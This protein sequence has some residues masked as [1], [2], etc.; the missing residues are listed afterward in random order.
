M[1]DTLFKLNHPWSIYLREPISSYTKYSIYHSELLRLLD[2]IVNLNI[3]IKNIKDNRVQ[4]TNFII[5]TPME[6]ALHKQNCSNIYMFQWQQLFPYHITKF[7]NY[8]EKLN[9]YVNINIIIISPDD[10]FMDENYKEPLFTSQCMDYKFTKVKNREYN[11]SKEKLTIKIDIFTCPF[12]QLEK[13][14]LTILK[15]DELI[16]KIAL[17]Q[18]DTLAPSLDDIKFIDNFYEHIE[19]IA[20]NPSSNMIINS[21]ATFRNVREYDNYGL[22]K[23][24]LELANK[25]KIIATEWSFSENNYFTKIMSTIKFTTDYIKYAVSYIDPCYSR[26]LIEKY[27]K[28]SLFET[29]KNSADIAM[30][31]IVVCILIKFPYNKL[32]LRKIKYMR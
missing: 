32:V 26:S 21:Y 27:E 22:F 23:S 2:F 4:L 14:K 11:Y 9:N 24:L 31:K 10:I 18:L 13:N 28:I 12:P 5:G 20:S 6:D 19:S 17:Y 15:S 30:G 1:T 8:H 29:K 16:K 7:I 25:Y 3:N